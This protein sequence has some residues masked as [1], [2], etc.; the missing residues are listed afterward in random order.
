MI[1]QNEPA[2]DDFIR[3]IDRLHN[4]TASYNET[5]QIK[6]VF[7]GSTVWQGSIHIFNVSGHPDTYTC[8]AWVSPIEGSD[9]RKIYA[10]LKI[11]PVDSPEKAVKAA[12]VQD[13]R[14]SEGQ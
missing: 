13:Y 8:Y 9:K 3:S 6:E 11:P 2:L 5:V 1:G 7:Q 12:I 10:V 14:D 4:C